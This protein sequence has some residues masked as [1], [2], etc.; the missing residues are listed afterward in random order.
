MDDDGRDWFGNPI[1]A[2]DRAPRAAVPCPAC[3]EPFADADALRSHIASDHDRRALPGGG[4]PGRPG[5][6]GRSPLDPSP[7]RRFVDGLR[8]VPL[9]FVLPL[10]VLFVWLVWLSL[11]DPLWNPVGA[12]VVRLSLLPLI[13]LLAA[14]V[15]GR[16]PR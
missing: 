13:L 12:M 6:R 8:F 11:S 15:A 1:G 10:N 2:D 4:R 7:W 3:G 16:K 14:R 5:R 9:W